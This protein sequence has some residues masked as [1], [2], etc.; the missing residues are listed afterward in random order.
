MDSFLN[1]SSTGPP[2]PSGRGME[3]LG[4]AGG[5]A[6][7]TPTLQSLTT[8]ESSLNLAAS[9]YNSASLERIGSTKPEPQAPPKNLQPS[10]QV[11]Q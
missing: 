10:A 3:G 1:P 7:P 6:N 11:T 2:P 4:G 8:P 9:A 5:S